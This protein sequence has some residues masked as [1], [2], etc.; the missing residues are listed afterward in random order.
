MRCFEQS[1]EHGE[2]S[3]PR[4]YGVADYNWNVANY[5]PIDN[6]E[7]GLI[8]LTPEAHEAY[9]TFAIHS[10]DIGE[11]VIA[12]QNHGKQDLPT[13]RLQ[14]K[15]LR[16]AVCRVRPCGES[17]ATDGAKLQEPTSDEGI[18]SPA[19]AEFKKLSEHEARREPS[20][21][22]RHSEAA[23]TTSSGATTSRT[24]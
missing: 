9:R 11:L 19:L 8:D 1:M 14:P 20:N 5:N 16:Q 4:L 6:W 12:V 23:T 24:V 7:R 18:T 17:T 13:R 10:C 21:S 15:R 2:A 3:K 22:C